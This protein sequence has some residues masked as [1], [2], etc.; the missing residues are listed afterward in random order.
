MNCP[1]PGTTTLK[2]PGNFID[3][4]KEGTGHSTQRG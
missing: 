4:L 2:T 1:F 3:N